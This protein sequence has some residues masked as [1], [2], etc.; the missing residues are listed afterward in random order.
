MLEGK[1][2]GAGE[3]RESLQSWYRCTC[4]EVGEG[5]GLGFSAG[6]RNGVGLN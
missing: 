3:G 4:D 5:G 6:L 2:V 1:G